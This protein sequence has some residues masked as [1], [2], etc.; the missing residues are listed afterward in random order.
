MT[1]VLDPTYGKDLTPKKAI[2]HGHIGFSNR[3]TFDANAFQELPTAYTIKGLF[4]LVV[5]FFGLQLQTADI[6]SAFKTYLDNVKLLT[7]K[8]RVVYDGEDLG[9]A[10]IESNGGRYPSCS[11]HFEIPNPL[12]DDTCEHLDNWRIGFE[13]RKGKWTIRHTEKNGFWNQPHRY[14]KTRQQMLDLVEK[15]RATRSEV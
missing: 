12:W 6:E 5:D 13:Y 4:D 1:E 11:L 10:L 7:V 2:L 3:I 15:I 8:T 9:P 14:P